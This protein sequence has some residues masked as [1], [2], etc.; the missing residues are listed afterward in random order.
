MVISQRRIK[1]QVYM[2][3]YNKQYY[4]TRIKPIRVKKPIRTWD[5]VRCVLCGMLSSPE[6]HKDQK[7]HFPDYFIVVPNHRLKHYPAEKITDPELVKQKQ[8]N[9][10]FYVG[11]KMIFILKSMYSNEELIQKFSLQNAIEFNKP[12]TFIESSKFQ[13]ATKLQ[14]AKKFENKRFEIADKFISA[15][16]LK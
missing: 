14:E 1:K 2:K 9:I 11:N 10:L 16:V 12:I 15:E 13:N 6:K 8:E 7:T 3:Q 4:L 5:M